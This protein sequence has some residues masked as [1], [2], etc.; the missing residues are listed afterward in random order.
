MDKD[1]IIR[2]NKELRTE[3]AINIHGITIHPVLYKDYDNYHSFVGCLLYN[4][5]YYKDIELSSLPRLY[6]LTSI[7]NDIK[8]ENIEDIAGHQQRRTLFVQL[9]GLLRLVLKDQP[10]Y[11]DETSKGS[12][13]F[14]LKVKTKDGDITINAKKFEQLREIILIQN[15][16]Y[17]DDEYIH[18]DILKW[19][20]EQ[21]K[22]DAKRESKNSFTT[23]E[24][25]LEALMI[26]FNTTDEHY[27]DNK[28]IRRVDRLISKITDRELYVAQ[29]TGSM[30]GM[31]K[32]KE[33]P[34]SW[35]STKL[36]QSDFDKYLKELK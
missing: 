14:A 24:D 33:S 3:S 27:F 10:F 25:R 21:K 1:L 26:E 17:Y 9:Y 15:N 11:F 23:V 7:L 13:Y 8:D 18:P 12:S 4:P 35:V 31:V 16:T 22:I 30:S 29:M 5:V 28:T 34:V 20:E 2:Y 19:I 36:P 6:F 32:F